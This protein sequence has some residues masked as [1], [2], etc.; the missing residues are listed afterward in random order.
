MLEP[1]DYDKLLTTPPE[2]K[3]E[4]PDPDNW[5]YSAGRWV[6]VGDEV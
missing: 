6:Y 4:R 1:F 2:E 3:P 5:V